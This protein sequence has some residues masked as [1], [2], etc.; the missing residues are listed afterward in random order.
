MGTILC[1]NCNYANED[2]LRYCIMCGT[3]VAKVCPNCQYANVPIAKY[4]GMCG[5]ALME[6]ALGSGTLLETNDS[7]SPPVVPINIESA[8]T[9]VPDARQVERLGTRELMGERHVASILLADVRGSTELMEQIGTEDWVDIMNRIFQVLEAEI[10]RMGGEIDQYRGDGVLAFFGASSVHADDPERAV[11]A[12][13]FIQRSFKQFAH[14]VQKQFPDIDLKLRVG[15]NSGEV[16]VTRIGNEQYFENTAMGGAVALAARMESSAEPGTVLVSQFTYQQTEN[17]FEYQDLG[18]ITVKGISEPV[19]VYRPLRP[20]KTKRRYS[21]AQQWIGRKEQVK[22]LRTA[23]ENL[24]K[25]NG[26]IVLVNGEK[27]MGK[28]FLVEHVRQEVKRNWI[29][30]A[31]NE[32]GEESSFSRPMGWFVGDCR[33][34]GQSWPYSVWFDLISNWLHFSVKQTHEELNIF[35]E[36]EALALWGEEKDRH[37]PYLQLFLNLP[38]DPAVEAKLE[39]MDAQT[40]QNNFFDAVCEWA[41]ALSEEKPLVLNISNIHW[42]DTSS[43]ELLKHCL[44]LVESHSIMFLITMRPVRTSPAWLF[45]HYL[46]TEYPHRLVWIEVPPL[47]PSEADQLIDQVLNEDSL[48]ENE[49]KIIF[50]RSEGNPFF[51]RE[52]IRSMIDRDVL[53][54]DSETN[55]WS[56]TDLDAVAELPDS[57][58]GILQEF[59]AS[60]SVE[61]RHVLQ[62]ASVIGNQFWD[63]LLGQVLEMEPE[64]LQK[65]LTSLQR[66][67]LI[68]EGGHEGILGIVYTFNSTLMRDAAYASLLKPQRS[69]YHLR[70]AELIESWVEEHVEDTSYLS[71]IYGYLA[72]HFNLAGKPEKEMH[73]HILAAE[74]AEKIHA[75]DEAIYHLNLAY[76]LTE[77]LLKETDEEGEQRRLFKIQFKVLSSRRWLRMMNADIRGSQR[78]AERIIQLTER[79]LANDPVLRIDAILI[80]AYP[81]AYAF[82]TVEESNR[83]CGMCEEALYL[84]RSI[85][86]RRREMELLSKITFLRANARDENVYEPAMQ[87]LE[88][89]KE[90]DDLD[91]QFNVL[92]N[93]GYYLI[94]R[95]QMAEGEKFI[96]QALE[97]SDR[98]NDPY[99]QMSALS[100]I[101]PSYERTG[102]YYRWM[103]EYEAKRLELSRKIGSRMAEGNSLMYYGMIRANYLGDLEGGLKMLHE[104]EA[105]LKK[106]PNRIFVLLRIAQCYFE[107]GNLSAAQENLDKAKPLSDE[108]VFELA[109][110]GYMLVQIMINN[111]E[112]DLEH[113]N[114]ALQ[115][116]EEIDKIGVE[117]NISQQYRMAAASHASSVHRK[118]AVT[119]GSMRDLTDETM[120]KRKGHLQQS[121]TKSELA[122]SIYDKFGYTNAAEITGEWIV[123]RMGQALIANG[124]RAEALPFIRRAYEEM[125]R[126]HDLIPEDSPY[127][128]TFLENITHH[129]QILSAFRLL[130]D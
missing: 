127:R 58:Q 75:N 87:A 35:F 52:I 20:I 97:L 7:A 29:L 90:L 125:M 61:D 34:Y 27:G 124:R 17:R 118:I 59:I 129:R 6:S 102:D 11:L 15:V 93:Y 84:A 72:H 31:S 69:A 83:M 68:T 62:V 50:E 49:R 74:C 77:A 89:A 38:I 47:E 12:A 79:E 122:V 13:L 111:E 9:P 5:H 56:I 78:D 57:L 121:L 101:G 104:S 107:L 54:L 63:L 44:P 100:V 94:G 110:V 120:E 53:V 117:Q 14:K 42:I 119:L 95:D 2:K 10:Y 91:M 40:Y 73:F 71:Q 37:A 108:Y 36:R 128:Q 123:Y 70:C 21:Q 86:D 28:S 1:P 126:K 46:G 109:R 30:Q 116:A 80:Y 41:R 85:Q 64:D 39:A 4:C 103:M 18:E 114:I 66:N 43:L 8:L 16:I 48:T 88:I 99:S 96:D 45:R 106:A 3:S 51:I 23:T 105:L 19:R 130:K 76:Q 98:V 33:S 32:P 67:Q 81:S 22:R 65:H 60:L 92:L 26:S 112:D 82:F 113:L 24:P 55:I 115:L 25:G